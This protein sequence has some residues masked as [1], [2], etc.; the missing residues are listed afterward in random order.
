MKKLLLTIL[1]SIASYAY[2]QVGI[3]TTTPNATVDVNGDLSIRGKIYVGGNDTTLGSPGVNGQ[4]L[5]SSGPGAP[6]KWLKL[7]IPDGE[8][9]YYLIYNNTFEDN[10]GIEFTSSEN[11]GNNVYTRGTLFSSLTNWKKIP[12]MTQTFD[13]YSD[14]NKVYF[15]FETVAQIATVSSTDY[16]DATEFACGIFVDGKLEGVR[17]NSVEQPSIAVSS[18]VTHTMLHVSENVSVGTHTLDVACT[19]RA[20]YDNTYLIGIGK[21]VNATNLNNF[22]AKSTMKVEVF[23]I[24]DN[25]VTVDP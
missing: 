16:L 25:Y 20:N 10:V 22:M 17:L 3:N 18:F 23:E 21:G 4:V 2:S 13:V 11:T 12:G 7:N 8:Q 1:V 24:P 5:V 14:E 9:K 6:P 15:T 19:R